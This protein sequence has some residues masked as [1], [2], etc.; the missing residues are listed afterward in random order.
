MQ[1][2]QLSL[3]VADTSFDRPVWTHG[4]GKLRNSGVTDLIMRSEVTAN[5]NFPGRYIQRRS[6]GFQRRINRNGER[7]STLR[8]KVFE[9]VPISMADLLFQRFAFPEGWAGWHSIN[10]HKRTH[11]KRTS[12]TFKAQSLVLELPLCP[13]CKAPRALPQDRAQA[14]LVTKPP[15]RYHDR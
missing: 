1:G 9:R 10:G 4:G 12:D 8:T 2:A 5:L 13:K 11:H 7:D 3:A 6:R 15:A 14:F